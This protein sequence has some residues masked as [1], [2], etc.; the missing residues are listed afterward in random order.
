MLKQGQ[1]IGMGN[2][3]VNLLVQVQEV[4][5]HTMRGWVINGCW[6]LH[7]NF[8]TALLACDTPTGT[9]HF[10]THILFTSPLPRGMRDYNEAIEYMNDHLKSSWYTRLWNRVY[11]ATI[12]RAHR[13]VELPT[14]LRNAIQ[15]MCK[16]W[17]GPLVVK[18]LPVDYDDDIPF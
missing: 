16:G 3:K 5:P 18:S 6:E 2:T 15:G 8:S 10:T 7:Y 14:R 11:M 1:L 4:T 12:S 9:T 17:S 13:V